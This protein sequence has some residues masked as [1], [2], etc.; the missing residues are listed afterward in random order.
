VVRHEPSSTSAGTSLGP[1][2]DSAQVEHEPGGN[3]AREDLLEALVHVV[4]LSGLRDHPSTALGVEV[5]AFDEVV[6][7]ADQRADDRDALW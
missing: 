2:S 6:A 7:C 5:K 4:E 1:A 3:S